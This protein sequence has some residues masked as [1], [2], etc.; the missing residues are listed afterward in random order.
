[1]TTLLIVLTLMLFLS[2]RERSAA[3]PASCRSWFSR[4][5]LSIE[6]GE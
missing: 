1:M 2:V 3:A 5:R 4:R 6:D